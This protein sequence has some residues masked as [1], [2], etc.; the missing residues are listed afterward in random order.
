MKR[1]DFYD[2]LFA[3][4]GIQTWDLRLCLYLN[5]KYDD[6][7]SSATKAGLLMPNCYVNIWGAG[8]T[9]KMQISKII[10]KLFA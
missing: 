7:D 1:I 8:L 4:S 9:D 3:S 6:L 10:D 2:K 5:L